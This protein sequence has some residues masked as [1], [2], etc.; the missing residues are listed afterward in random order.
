MLRVLTWPLMAG[1]LFLT[2]TLWWHERQAITGAADLT[3]NVAD[4]P[5]AAG[6]NI[7][8]IKSNEVELCLLEPRRSLS[9]VGAA[10][11]RCS[12][13]AE[14][15]MPSALE[16]ACGG[17]RDSGSQGS[18]MTFSAALALQMASLPGECPITTFHFVKLS[19]LCLA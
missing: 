5:E 11:R 2:S 12:S 13:D 10:C 4:A 16:S 14:T 7:P 8:N 1:I 3:F 6:L 15:E 9:N 18:E 19:T 17:V